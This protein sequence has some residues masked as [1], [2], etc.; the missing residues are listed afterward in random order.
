MMGGLEHR[1]QACLPSPDD[2]AASVT[3]ALAVIATTD[4]P[5]EYFLIASS[6]S[7]RVC[8]WDPSTVA[9]VC[10]RCFLSISSIGNLSIFVSVERVPQQLATRDVPDRNENSLQGIK[11]QPLKFLVAKTLGAS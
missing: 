5:M 3:A 7:R 9:S 2:A 8:S 6:A 11:P 10:D 1:L 4:S